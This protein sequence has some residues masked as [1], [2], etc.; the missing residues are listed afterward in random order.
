MTVSKRVYQRLSREEWSQL[1]HEYEEGEE[2]QAD[3]CERRGLSIS[4]FHSWR[5]RLRQKESHELSVSSSPFIEVMRSGDSPPGHWDVE[6]DLG[7]DTV[8]RL[9]RRQCSR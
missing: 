3:F 4:T 8:L 1:M 9:R 6:L 7:G 2:S 5:A